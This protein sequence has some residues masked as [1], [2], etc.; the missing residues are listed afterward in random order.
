MGLPESVLTKTTLMKS[1]AEALWCC[2]DHVL[3]KTNTDNR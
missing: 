1:L 2:P 3:L